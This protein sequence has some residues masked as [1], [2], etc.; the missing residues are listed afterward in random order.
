MAVGAKQE[1]LT[2]VMRSPGA[3]QAR[4]SFGSYRELSAPACHSPPAPYCCFSSL[5]VCEQ[6]GLPESS[7]GTALQLFGAAHPGAPW[8]HV[9]L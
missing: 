8:E 3:D 2:N 7:V 5:P 9:P 6:E 4:D 1:S